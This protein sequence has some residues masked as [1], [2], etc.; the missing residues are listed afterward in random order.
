MPAGPSGS[1]RSPPVYL[2]GKHESALAV[3]E[4]WFG[5]PDWLTPHRFTNMALPDLAKLLFPGFYACSFFNVRSSCMGSSE[6]NIVRNTS[7]EKSWLLSDEAD[8]VSIPR[9]FKISQISSHKLH[10]AFRWIVKALNHGHDGALSAT[11]WTN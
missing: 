9:N 6:S 1:R 11:R 4:W 2:T 8:L 5:W 3:Y 10:D 7:V